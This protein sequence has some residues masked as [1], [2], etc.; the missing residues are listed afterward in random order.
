MEGQ[1]SSHCFGLRQT[2]DAGFPLL[3][4]IGWDTS[5]GWLEPSF[6]M[7][8]N[9]PGQGSGHIS[10]APPQ[11]ERPDGAQA[12]PFTVHVLSC[13]LN[14]SCPHL[15]FSRRHSGKESA[16]QRRRR[17]KCGVDPWIGKIP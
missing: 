7:E 1:S 4:L 2:G 15:G 5:S 11:E 9:R 16:C 10:Q 3:R 6:Q 17:K 14:Y 13:F 8:V 12:T